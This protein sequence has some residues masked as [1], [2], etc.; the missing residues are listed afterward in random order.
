MPLTTVQDRSVVFAA[1]TLFCNAKAYR[2]SHAVRHTANKTPYFSML[3]IKLPAHAHQLHTTVASQWSVFSKWLCHSCCAVCHLLLALYM[4]CTTVLYVL[5]P[6]GTSMALPGNCCKFPDHYHH[7]DH[8]GSCCHVHAQF[9]AIVVGCNISACV[10][11][12][13]N[14]GASDLCFASS[15]SW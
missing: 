14:S 10:Q 7:P 5:A 6:P 12:S 9:M 15:P 13:A 3:C 11:A 2:A 8:S 4:C 1:N